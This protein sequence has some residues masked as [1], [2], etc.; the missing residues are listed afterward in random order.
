MS[1]RRVD[2]NFQTTD[3][4]RK[5]EDIMI[6]KDRVILWADNLKDNYHRLDDNLGHDLVEV[7]KMKSESQ[8]TFAAN[9]NLTPMYRPKTF[10]SGVANA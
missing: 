4:S 3:S 6:G 1:Y 10:S 2:D 9:M 5:S 7:V 8:I